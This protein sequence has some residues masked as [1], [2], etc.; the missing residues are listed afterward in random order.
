[1]RSS[2]PGSPLSEKGFQ[3]KM[4]IGLSEVYGGRTSGSP[5]VGGSCGVRGG[6]GE[7]AGAL[8]GCGWAW[9]TGPVGALES[10]A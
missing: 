9:G 5:S 7:L 3:P 10:E 1:M 6:H 4:V 8:G 2:R